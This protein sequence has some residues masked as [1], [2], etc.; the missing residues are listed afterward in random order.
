MVAPGLGIGCEAGM[1]IFKAILDNY[2]G[3]HFIKSDKSLN[4][5]TVVNYTSEILAKFGMK[6]TSDLHQVGGIWVY[7]KDYFCPYDI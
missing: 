5:K 4:L 3:E 2:S 1:P 6:A 7:P